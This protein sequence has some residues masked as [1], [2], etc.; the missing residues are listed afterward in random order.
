MGPSADRAIVSWNRHRGIKA[1]TPSTDH[2]CRLRARVRGRVGAWAQPVPECPSRRK[3]TEPRCNRPPSADPGPSTGPGAAAP[4]AARDKCR[5]PDALRF[6][7][8]TNSIRRP[9]TH[10]KS[11]QGRT[12]D[13]WQR[14]HKRPIP[15][16]DP[17]SP[18]MIRSTTRS[19]AVSTG[20]CRL[21][22]RM[23]ASLRRTDLLEGRGAAPR[24]C[25]EALPSTI[26]TR[27]VATSTESGG[28]SPTSS[29]RRGA[30][31]KR[32]LREVCR[33]ENGRYGL[34][35]IGGSRC[36]GSTIWALPGESEKTPAT[37][38][39]A[40][41]RCEPDVLHQASSGRRAPARRQS[42]SLG[43]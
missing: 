38:A 20:G 42:A 10:V 27:R 9:G 1:R 24:R 32:R 25:P 6:G 34:P 16:D 37:P 28:P 43:R 26:R 33:V 23:Q 29:T 21:H 13:V 15:E 39:P 31:P 18:K 36:L 19:F 30:S 17:R 12:E 35:H 2:S 7:S 3:T 40:P 5:D 41:S 8:G 4:A 11:I 14:I 22:R